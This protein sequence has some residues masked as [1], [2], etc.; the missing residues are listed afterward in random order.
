MRV[1]ILICA[2]LHA[3]QLL[4]AQEEVSVTEALDQMAEAIRAEAFESA[5][6]LSVWIQGQ[7]LTPYEEIRWSENQLRLYRSQNEYVKEAELRDQLLGQLGAWAE[8]S[9]GVVADSLLSIQA[10]TLLNQGN[11]FYRQGRYEQSGKYLREFLALI[12]K[13]EDPL[14]E[15]KGLNLKGVLFYYAGDLDS[16]VLQ[17]DEVTRKALAAGDSTL[18][19]NSLG[20]TATI[21]KGLGNLEASLSRYQEVLQFGIST[22]DTTSILRGTTG[23]GQVYYDLQDND[24]ALAYFRWNVALA[25]KMGSPYQTAFGASDLADVYKRVEQYDSAIHFYGLSLHLR[26]QTGDIAGQA[27]VLE[28]LGDLYYRQNELETALAYV[29]SGLVI[30]EAEQLAEE[31]FLLN[32]SKSRLLR[33]QGLP[34]E[35]L[36]YALAGKQWA[37][38]TGRWDHRGDAAEELY[39]VYELLGQKALAFDQLKIHFEVEDS[40]RGEATTRRIARLEYQYQAEQERQLREAESE[41]E[42]SLFE[43][44]LRLR[45]WILVGVCIILALAVWL[46]FTYRRFFQRQQ[47]D[48]Q[49]LSRLVQ[50]LEVKNEELIQLRLVEKERSEETLAIKDSAL[51]A[52][53]MTSHEKDA[54]LEQIT[55]RVQRLEEHLGAQHKPELRSIYKDLNDTVNKE[56]SWDSFLHRFEAV[57]PHFFERLKRDY[58]VL[59]NNDLKISAYVK[60]GMTNKDIAQVTHLA[61]ASVKKNLN[62]LKKKLNLSAE[63]SIRDFMLEY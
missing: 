18:W 8:E 62:R 20:N 63:D 11:H 41:K 57:H 23:I 51:A 15:V 25:Q 33:K 3:P 47:S 28:R 49:R 52:M 53:A 7:S 38:S 42:R 1:I 17:F 10:E 29:D 13:V 31:N 4:M 37:D 30:A 16:A 34:R 24:S 12:P 2:L 59:T 6:S 5:D 58:P 60:V 39:Q 9:S 55:Q 35:A 32:G 21:Y 46:A 54:I 26:K 48:S 56:E 14:L 27:Y 22:Q 43:A 44:R 45:N 36:P 50:Q 19:I 40:V 61:V